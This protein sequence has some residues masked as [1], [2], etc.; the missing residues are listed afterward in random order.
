MDTR[1]SPFDTLPRELIRHILFFACPGREALS[2]AKTISRQFRGISNGIEKMLPFI[3]KVLHNFANDNLPHLF[4]IRS[5]QNISAAG[6]DIFITIS[7][8]G[9]N[10]S[11]AT[12]YVWEWDEELETELYWKRILTTLE[13]G[14]NNFALLKKTVKDKENNS[15]YLVITIHNSG[16]LRIWN[17]ATG[18]DEEFNIQPFLNGTWMRCIA[19]VDN[20][21]VLGCEDGTL[22]TIRNPA[23]DLTPTSFAKHTKSV[24][25]IKTW[26]DDFIVSGS[27]DDTACVWSL[28]GELIAKL[29][30]N[31]TV[32]CIDILDNTHIV[33]GTADGNLRIWERQKN[34]AETSFTC[35][36]Y[37]EA[38]T[39][40]AITCITTYENKIIVGHEDSTIQ[41]FDNK[42]KLIAAL[43]GDGTA[44]SGIAITIDKKIIST[45]YNSTIKVWPS[46][47]L[48][49]QA[50]LLSS[51]TPL[52]PQE[53]TIRP[54][55]NLCSF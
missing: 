40:N 44:V 32:Q 50:N 17:P 26:G 52:E 21:I 16:T 3:P 33:T 49:P 9:S 37:I 6:K 36:Q 25:C 53:N 13:D 35:C 18:K 29:P 42:G 41:T 27:E 38:E 51:D 28:N 54:R 43:Q 46:Y 39:I 1:P 22:W 15:L 7:S 31:H 30:H 10:S 24:R 2:T 8:D 55:A 12:L 34:N 23:E 45:Y 4:P 11:N 5:L 19:I 14:I 20:Q 48:D 47:I